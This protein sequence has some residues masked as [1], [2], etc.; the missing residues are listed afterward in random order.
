MALVTLNLSRREESLKSLEKLPPLSPLFLRL[1]GV[2]ANPDCHV[3]EL[4]SL[5]EK[6]VL[7]SAQI[8]RRANSAVFRRR[9]PIHS[10]PH[11]V[12]LLGVGTMRRFVLASSVSTLLFRKHTARNF[13][14]TR[15]NIHS[16]ATGTL[17]ELLADQL[18]TKQ[19]HHA[20]LAGLLHDIGKALMAIHMSE[21]YEDVLGAIAVSGVPAVECERELAGVDH[22]EL[23]AFAVAHWG[24]DDA[25]RIAV[26]DHHEPWSETRPD[27]PSAI[28]L[29]AIVNRADAFVNYLGMSV[30]PPALNN[31][32]PPDLEFPGMAGSADDVEQRF[33]AEWD[34]LWKL[35]R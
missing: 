30:L 12:A 6:D 28:T 31:P 24:L 1:L 15:F 5:V 2:L 18:P 3:S 11:A 13:S 9:Q 27:D 34:T 7:L 26:H 20:F 19:R 25:V 16:V 8:L 35:L 14:M 29:A 23:S 21:L 32:V 22:A 17:T 4:V 10:V 33:H